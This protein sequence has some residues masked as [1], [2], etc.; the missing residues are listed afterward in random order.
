M[1][2]AIPIVFPDYRISVNQA[3]TKVDLIKG[4]SWD[5]FT[6]PGYKAR[7]EGLG[8]AGVF[9]INGK[10]GVTKYYEYG[11]Y[12]PAGLG[13]VNNLAIPNVIVREGKIVDESL[14]APLHRI[15]LKAGHG[16]RIE[17][18]YIEVESGFEQMLKYA[19]LRELQNNNPKRERYGLLSYSCV[20]FAKEVVAAAGV[21]TP[22]M[23]DPRP[24]SYIGEF[25]D[26]YPD[27]DYFPRT[28][29]LKIEGRAAAA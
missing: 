15:A 29:E 11:R 20:H 16:G 12:D 27:L 7:W 1:D 21:D 5:N 28:R 9:F 24:N 18:V 26:D 8:H 10:N 25:R 19:Q 17:G 4:V 14:K 3:Q 13:K 6:L 22:W 23:L 2:V